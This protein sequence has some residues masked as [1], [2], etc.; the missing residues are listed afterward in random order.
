[1][2]KKKKKKKLAKI[3]R[4]N[5]QRSKEIETEIEDLYYLVAGVKGVNPYKQPGTTNNMIKE[6]AR[7]KS[8]DKVEAMENYRKWN[9]QTAK[10]IK[11]VI[12]KVDPSKKDIVVDL[13]IK[14]LGYQTVCEKY[15]YTNPKN[16]HKDVNSALR[17]AINRTNF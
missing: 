15:G 16:L 5:I 14:D 10:I 13:L 2:K 8:A 11:T 1:M 12:N 3:Y 9:I 7:L 17:E 4:F 6:L